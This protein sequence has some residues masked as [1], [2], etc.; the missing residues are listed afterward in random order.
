[1]AVTPA[2]IKELRAR[3]EAGFMDCKKALDECDGDMEKAIDWLRKKGAS[4]N[5]KEHMPRQRDTRTHR[6]PGTAVFWRVLAQG[7][8]EEK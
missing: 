3:T 5:G 1:M 6:K 7:K 2:M 4:K 8:G